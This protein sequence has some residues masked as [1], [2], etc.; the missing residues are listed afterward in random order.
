MLPI[1]MIFIFVVPKKLITSI[2][3]NATLSTATKT[4]SSPLSHSS[5]ESKTSEIF[6]S[7]WTDSIVRGSKP[8]NVRHN[9]IASILSNLIIILISLNDFFYLKFKIKYSSKTGVT[10]NAG[11]QSSEVQEPTSLS[12]LSR[13][14]CINRNVFHLHL[15]LIW[16]NAGGFLA[17]LLHQGS[18]TEKLK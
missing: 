15:S 3:I 8:S 11:Y 4:T 1:C 6:S 2:N 5:W 12:P 16:L 17:S 9:I 10:L 13:N 14:W 7:L 18:K